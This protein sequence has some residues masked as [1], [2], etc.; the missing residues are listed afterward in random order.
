MQGDA[1]FGPKEIGLG[2]SVALA[3]GGLIGLERQRHSESERRASLGGARTFALVALLGALLALLGQVQGAALPIAGLVAV[4]AL[5]VVGTLGAREEHE[6]EPGGDVP[7][8]SATALA[9]LVVYAIGALPFVPLPGLSFPARLVVSAGLGVVVLALLALRRPI[10][11]FAEQLSQEDLLATVRFALVALVALPLLPDRAYD[12]YGALNPFR[13]GVVIVLIAGISFVGYVAARLWGARRGLGV[14]A[15]AGGL[16]SSTAVTLTFSSRARAEAAL[17]PAYALGIALAATVLFAR[18]LAEVAAIEPALVARTA[19]PLGVMLATGLLGCLALWRRSA[20][21]ARCEPPAGLQNPFRLRPA[22]RLGLV[23]AAIRLVAAAAWERFGAQGL[24]V[25][26]AL[27]G[28][29]DVDAITIS[30][31]R[32]H[33]AGLETADA[34]AAIAVATV[35]NTLVKAVLAVALGGRALGLRVAAVLLPVAAAGAGVAVWRL[36]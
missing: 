22:L 34:V 27:A 32:M 30:V 25:S 21:L 1:G 31:A 16:V 29:T 9:A 6:D 17:V 18:V 8:A 13:I 14:T 12:R 19:E 3:V 4:L 23:Y 5:Q 24:L 11:A 2:L 20:A 10:H 7:T 28:T 15:L 26:A 33:G 36:G 35:T